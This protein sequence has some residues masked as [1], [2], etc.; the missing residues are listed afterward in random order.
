MYTAFKK[1]DVIFKSWGMSEPASVNIFWGVHVSY[2]NDQST[3]DE[4]N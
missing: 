4:R 3:I 2:Y 1:V